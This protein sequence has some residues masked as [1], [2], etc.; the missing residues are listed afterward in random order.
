MRGRDTTAACL[1]GWMACTL[2][3]MPAQ[4]TSIIEIESPAALQQA[5]CAADPG[6]EHIVVLPAALF[7]DA[8]ELIC[9]TG[10]YKLYRIQENKDPDDFEYY[11]DPPFG[12][13]GRLA[14]DGKAGR[15]MG[16]IAVNCRPV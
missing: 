15:A 3:Q 4:A 7:V 10:P 14:C 12:T 8:K 9:S 2:V 16:V 6:M 11:I 5:F 13:R 1:L